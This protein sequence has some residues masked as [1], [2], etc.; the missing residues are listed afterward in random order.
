MYKGIDATGNNLVRKEALIKDNF[1]R[2]L[3]FFIRKIKP[4]TF[5][6]QQFRS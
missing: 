4:P 6:C 3:V 5:I 1:D 2:F